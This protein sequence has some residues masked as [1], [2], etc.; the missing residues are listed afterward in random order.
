MV[1]DALLMCKRRPFAT[2]KMPF[3]KAF[4][5]RLDINTLQSAQKKD[6]AAFVSHQHSDFVKV[7]QTVRSFIPLFLFGYAEQAPTWLFVH[8]IAPVYKSTLCCRS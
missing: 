6:S 5:N 4:Y 7:F 3:Y 8:D 1:K 2:Q